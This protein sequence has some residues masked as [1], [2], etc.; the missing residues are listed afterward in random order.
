MICKEFEN[1]ILEKDGYTQAGQLKAQRYRQPD[2][3]YLLDHLRQCRSCAQLHDIDVGLEKS[4][5]AAFE[6]RDMPDG[7]MDQ[8]DI[9]IDH[10]E[11]GRHGSGVYKMIAPAAG[12]LMALAT[13]VFFYVTR[14][15]EYKTLE[16]LS[17]TAVARHLVGNRDIFYTADKMKQAL[18]LMSKELEFN[19]ILPNLEPQGYVLLGGRLC[20]LGKC[21]IAYIFYEKQGKPCSLFILD[22]D[23]LAFKMADGSRFSNDLKGLHTDIWKE[24][25]QVYALVF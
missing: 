10:A 6:P 5:H 11:E 9:A 23:R 3:E 12:I 4:I 15:V 7:L 1:W 2:Q 14:P 19:V 13:V 21:K 18:V 8:V 20:V 17:E 25:S 24:N 16:Q 22:Y